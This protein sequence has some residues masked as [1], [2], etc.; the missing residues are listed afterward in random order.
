MTFQ[1]GPGPL[2]SVCLPHLESVRPVCT[3]LV[4]QHGPQ[5]SFRSPLRC[6]SSQ[7][8]PR[9]GVCSTSAVLFARIFVLSTQRCG[10]VCECRESLLSHPFS[11]ETWWNDSIARL[12]SY[13]EGILLIQFGD[14]RPSPGAVFCFS[15]PQ[16]IVSVLW[17]LYDLS[18]IFCYPC[19]VPLRCIFDTL[20]EFFGF[21][22]SL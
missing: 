10:T 22:M 11:Y 14:S 21:Q 18:F 16:Q 15:S 9:A 7:R 19:G 17:M 2:F 4:H 20:N 12:C 8:A 6:S 5:C 1:Q 13:L 3:G